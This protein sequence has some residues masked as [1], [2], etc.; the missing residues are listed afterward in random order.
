MYQMLNDI[1]VTIKIQ[2]FKLVVE[3]LAH[4]SE[5]ELTTTITNSC[6]TIVI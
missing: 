1:A 5:L 6:A 2:F 4:M 3:L